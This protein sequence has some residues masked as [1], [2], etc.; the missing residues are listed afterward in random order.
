MNL[1]DLGEEKRNERGIDRSSQ[2]PLKIKNR[3]QG[4]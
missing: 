1:N 3:A 4:H 2:D